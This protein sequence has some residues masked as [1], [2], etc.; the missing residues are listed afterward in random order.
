M[1]T[2]INIFQ[3]DI[4]IKNNGTIVNTVLTIG[5]ITPI[6]EGKW[7]CRIRLPLI[8]EDTSIYGTD[9]L[10]ALLNCIFFA[11]ELMRQSAQNDTM[12]YWNYEGDLAGLE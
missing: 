12:V 1:D 7:T 4:H 2:T 3:R 6:C 10:A 11:K 9:G 5:P 8:C